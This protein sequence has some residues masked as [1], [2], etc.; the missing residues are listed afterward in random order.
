[1][2]NNIKDR[3]SKEV[4]IQLK[5]A[6]IQKNILIKNIYKEYEIY[7]QIVRKLILGSTEKGIFGL[8]SGLSISDEVLNS[9]GLNYFLNNNISLLINSKLPLITIEQ[10]KIAYINDSP[11]KLVDVNSF[12]QLGEFKEYKTVYFDY[13]KQL[14][15][16]ESLKFNCNNNSTTYKYYES[17]TKD[18]LS[19]VNLDE[20]Q[21]LDS[22]PKQNSI[23]KIENEKNIVDPIIEFSEEKDDSKLNDYEK[24]NKERDFFLQWGNLNFFESIDISFSNFLLKLSYR[25]NLELLKINLIKNI[26]SEDSFKNLLN[27]KHIIQNPYPFVIRYDLNQTNLSLDNKFSDDYLLNITNIELEFYNLELSICKN[28]INELKNKFRLLIKKQT[29]WKNKELIL[30]NLN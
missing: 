16:K 14:M 30:N 24:L 15:T 10:L 8:Y 9:K 21:Y 12:R 20:N 1:M 22:Y 19:S 27:N 26:I 23:K 28:N 17:L 7:F 25:I 13:E 11:K 3:N 6:E 4:I 2:N 29:Y 18:E 5:R